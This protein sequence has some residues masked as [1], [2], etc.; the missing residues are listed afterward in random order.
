MTKNR[1]LKN[2]ETASALVAQMPY[3]TRRVVV[4]DGYY[5]AMNSF[6]DKLLQGED[7]MQNAKIQQLLD[8]LSA[9]LMADVAK[10]QE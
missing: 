8:E 10:A 2:D 7:E 4:T 5:S 3:V 6:T 1:A 9:F